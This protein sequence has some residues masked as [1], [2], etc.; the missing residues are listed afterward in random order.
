MN[1]QGTVYHGLPP[2]LLPFNPA[3]GDY[4]AFVGRISPEKRADRAIALAKRQACRSG[5]PPRSI[6]RMA[7]FRA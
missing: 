3:G 5:S 4:L 2:D 1:W 6:R 7:V